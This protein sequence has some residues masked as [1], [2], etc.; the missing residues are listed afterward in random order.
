LSPSD[1]LD[2]GDDLDASDGAKESFGNN[3]PNAES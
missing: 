1:I 2:A 3:L